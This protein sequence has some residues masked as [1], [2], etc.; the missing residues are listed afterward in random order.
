M[1]IR[2]S[3]EWKTAFRTHYGHF[4]YKVMPFGLT[5]IPTTFQGYINQILAA[6]LDVLMIVYLDD[7]L[8][9]IKS[10]GEEHVKTVR[11]VLDQLRRYSLYANL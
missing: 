11:W 7:I 9:Y 3:D 5:N 2:E 4:E 10:K 8:I 1:R 6:K